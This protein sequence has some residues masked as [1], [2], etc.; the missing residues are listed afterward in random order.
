M[1]DLP[2]GEQF[3]HGRKQSFVKLVQAVE[4]GHG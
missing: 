2:F 4:I 1:I 3:N